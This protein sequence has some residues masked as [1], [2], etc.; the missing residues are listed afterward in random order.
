[1]ASTQRNVS[2]LFAVAILIVIAISESNGQGGLL[3]K[4][5]DFGKDISNNVQCLPHIAECDVKKPNDEVSGFINRVNHANDLLSRT[6]RVLDR[7]S[8]TICWLRVLIRTRDA[9]R[10]ANSLIMTARVLE[11]P[12]PTRDYLYDHSQS[13]VLKTQSCL[14]NCPLTINFCHTVLPQDKD[15][16]RVTCC[17]LAAYQ[18]CVKT[19]IE[20]HCPGSFLGKVRS[21]FSVSNYNLRNQLIVKSTLQSS[22]TSS[23]TATSSGH[24]N[25]S[26]PI[27]CWQWLARESD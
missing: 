6:S 1:M 2:L 10:H 17:M 24:P 7:S 4:I 18:L 8:A 22:S 19:Q 3:D 25:A 15:N 14:L 23:A 9:F 12:F 13:R 20:I 16:K 11:C 27:T 21:Y 5:G 26:T